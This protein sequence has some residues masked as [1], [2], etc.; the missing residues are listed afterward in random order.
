MI[1]IIRAMCLLLA[2]SL[3]FAVQAEETERYGKQKVV[4][5]INSEGGDGSKKHLGAMRNIQNHINAVGAENIDVKVVLTL[6][7]SL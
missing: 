2:T 7:T 1:N 6:P 3:A 4:Y 5:H